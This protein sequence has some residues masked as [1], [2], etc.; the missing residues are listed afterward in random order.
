MKPV[1]FLKNW[2]KWI[3]RLGSSLTTTVNAFQKTHR[4]ETENT[5]SP[6]GG[7]AR[8]GPAL[9]QQAFGGENQ[10][11]QPDDAKTDQASMVEG[12]P[13]QVNAAQELQGG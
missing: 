6:L 1:K 4:R 9:Y 8:Q 10:Q 7:G 5:E 13:V 3:C 2:R 11:R 12:F